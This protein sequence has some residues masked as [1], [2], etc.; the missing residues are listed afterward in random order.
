[1]RRVRTLQ[2]AN[3]R[4]PTSMLAAASSRARIYIRRESLTFGQSSIDF[5]TSPWRNRL[6]CDF[7]DVNSALNQVRGVK[8]APHKESHHHNWLKTP[9]AESE[10]A[11]PRPGRPISFCAQF[12]AAP[13]FAL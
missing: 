12:R 2:L 1:M 8:T 9:V 10:R 3:S 6:I 5:A 11:K 7:P 4:L 13:N